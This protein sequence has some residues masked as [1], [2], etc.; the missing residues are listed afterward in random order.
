MTTYA[1]TLDGTVYVYVRGR[2]V[3]RRWLATGVEAV[4]H[5]APA[6]VRW[7]R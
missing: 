7:S 5:V 6:G 4:F 3:M 2:L 1:I